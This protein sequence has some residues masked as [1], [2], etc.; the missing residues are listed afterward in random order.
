[1]FKRAQWKSSANSGHKWG[2]YWAPL[3][4]LLF[5]RRD[6]L[7]SWL[8]SAKGRQS[9]TWETDW[10]IWRRRWLL[11][12]FTI[13]SNCEITICYCNYYMFSLAVW[14]FALFQFKK[15][16]FQLNLLVRLSSS[17]ICE[18]SLTSSHPLLCFP[19]LPLSPSALVQHPSTCV[20]FFHPLSLKDAFKNSGLSCSPLVKNQG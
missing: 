10:F 8:W 11:L 16:I 9:P 3:I 7:P 1:M 6:F 2:V 14:N 18:M 5:P 13:S 15:V 17:V 19:R 20:S 12:H 4:L